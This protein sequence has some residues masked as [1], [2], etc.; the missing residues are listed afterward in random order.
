MRKQTCFSTLGFVLFL[1][2]FN[3]GTAKKIEALKPAPSNQTPVVYSNKL[4]LI[5]M[6][7]E[8]SLKENRNESVEN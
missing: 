1:T 2:L 3:C 5:A 8:V 6:P 4:S 7:M